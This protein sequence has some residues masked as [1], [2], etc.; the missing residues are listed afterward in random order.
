MPQLRLKPRAK[1][2]IAS[3]PPKLKQQIK[4]SMLSLQSHPRPQDARPLIGYENYNRIDVGEYRVIYRYESK[5][6]LITVVLVG[7]RNDDA[8]YRIARRVLK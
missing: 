6:D 2:A 7:K 4:K 5:E 3:L 8:I 1:K